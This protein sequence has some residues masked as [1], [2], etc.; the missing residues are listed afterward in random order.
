M[1]DQS[2]PPNSFGRLAM[3]FVAAGLLLSMPAAA[4]SVRRDVDGP[5]QAQQQADAQQDRIEELQTQLTQ[6]TADNENLQRQL[7][8]AKREIARLQ[9]MV[10]NLAQV[11]QDISSGQPQPAD[12]AAPSGA[13]SSP[14]QPLQPG[15]GGG[16]A[17][18]DGGP[19]PQGQLG[20]LPASQTPD[21]GDI[22]SQAQDALR[23]GQYAEA[24]A[25]FADLLERFPTASV[26][27]DARFWYAFTLLARHND[28]DAA[29]NFI[30]YLHDAPN[31]ARAPEAQ[32]RLGMAFA[33][34]GQTQQA[35]T[36][37]LNLP[38]RY[39]RAPANIRSLAVNEAA[40]NHC[41]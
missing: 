2:A 28:Q 27:T 23:N 36:F 34:M 31:A 16:S 20:T 6:S 19:L 17:S 37:Y 9:A 38:Q 40:R 11:N 4:Q 7:L 33:E 32:V 22:Y 5:S 21:P 13:P 8:D 29:R 41:H 26:A 25:Q 3:A 12:G 10:G 35:C 30:Q 39:P 24:E 15:G 18:L 14:A 1:T